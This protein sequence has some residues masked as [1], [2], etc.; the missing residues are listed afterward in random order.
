VIFLIEYERATGIMQMQRFKDADSAAARAERLRL[1]LD[2][3]A[4]K[5]MREIVILEAKSEDQLRR[6]H[7]RYFESLSQ[8]ANPDSALKALR[9]A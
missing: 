2:R 7:R 8:L 4:S 1:E 5:L 9:A 3:A 6:T